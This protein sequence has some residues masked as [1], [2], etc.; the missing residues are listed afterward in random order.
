MPLAS[1]I[2][3]L[4]ITVWSMIPDFIKRIIMP[5][6]LIL[7]IHHGLTKGQR[8]CPKSTES[9]PS[10]LLL[11]YSQMDATYPLSFLAHQLAGPAFM[12]MLDNVGFPQNLALDLFHHT[13]QLVA[14]ALDKHHCGSEG[15]RNHM[16]AFSNSQGLLGN[17]G[18]DQLL[19]RVVVVVESGHLCSHWTP[20]CS[21]QQQMDELGRWTLQARMKRMTFFHSF[22]LYPI[23][24]GNDAL[25]ISKPLRSTIGLH[26]QYIQIRRKQHQ[27]TV[28]PCL[29]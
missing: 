8:H 17:W 22:A 28:G 16:H 4:Q 26:I 5:K 18:L 21:C 7:A 14:E 1:V 2:A 11:Q 20:S 19:P 15:A 6:L 23:R 10:T 27:R 13:S 25:M 12:T 9:V 24:G 3:P 29:F